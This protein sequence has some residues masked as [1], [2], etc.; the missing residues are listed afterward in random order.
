MSHYT[1]NDGFNGLWVRG[2][3]TF[4]PSES[5]GLTEPI[6]TT[7]GLNINFFEDLAM[8]NHG[9]LFVM[10]LKVN[11]LSDSIV[12]EG[13]ASLST[14]SDMVNTSNY[15]LQLGEK[16]CLAPPLTRDQEFRA[17][18][19]GS[20]SVA[21]L[22]PLTV[23]KNRYQSELHQMEN[24]LCLYDIINNS[25]LEKPKKDE[26]KHKIST[27]AEDQMSPISCHLNS[28][29]QL[30]NSVVHTCD[31]DIDKTLNALYSIYSQSDFNV[32]NTFRDLN[33]SSKFLDGLILINDSTKWI[34]DGGE[35]GIFDS[36]IQT[37]TNLR[38]L[39]DCS[40]DAY[41]MSARAVVTHSL[42]VGRL[43]DQFYCPSVYRGSRCVINIITE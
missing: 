6:Y 23:P 41:K 8:L 18:T 9:N 20:E 4:A 32:F 10:P 30:W 27:L 1:I 17:C 34:S 22:F 11:S 2:Q 37:L 36:I 13:E 28:G 40:M 3:G 26:F 24:F 5:I 21:H 29:N 16:V 31:G 25:V 42:E 33:T 14:A 38:F 39:C 19:I 12:V 43:S 7:D 35:N 15:R